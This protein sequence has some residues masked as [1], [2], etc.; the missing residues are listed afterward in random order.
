MLH[1][2]LLACLA[3]ACALPAQGA[4][5]AG[6]EARML[7]RGLELLSRGDSKSVCEG[8]KLLGGGPKDSREAVA[9]LLPHV[10]S[11]NEAVRDCVTA[12]L[13]KL[14]AAPVLLEAFQ[15]P[16]RRHQ[17][18]QQAV[19]LPHPGLLALYREA[20]KDE[21]PEIRAKAATGLKQQPAGPE[22]LDLLA[23]LAA[24]PVKNVRWWAID[25]L[26]VLHHRG[27]KEARPVLEARRKAEADPSLLPFIDKALK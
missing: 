3:L 5:R 15:D 17:A 12:A 16:G 25:S 14:D 11:R 2:L 23:R 18:L 13:A 22:V 19:Y 10:T 6:K 8:A 24:D 27:V 4:G 1:M 9:A 21:K 20:A 7:K 26:G